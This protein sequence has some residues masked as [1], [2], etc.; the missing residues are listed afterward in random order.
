MKPANEIPFM[1][2]D[3]GYVYTGFDEIDEEDYLMLGSYLTSGGIPWRDIQH[4]EAMVDDLS[5][6]GSLARE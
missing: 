1:T 4:L 6:P 5:K 2:T 3:Y